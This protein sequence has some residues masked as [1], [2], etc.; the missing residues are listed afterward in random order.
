MAGLL[1]RMGHGGYCEL[2]SALLSILCR[3]SLTFL[4]R[5]LFGD[6]AVGHRADVPQ[7]TWEE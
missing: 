1:A 5:A 7:N 2:V 3:S 4:Y 6:D